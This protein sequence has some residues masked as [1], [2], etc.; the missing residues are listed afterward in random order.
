LILLLAGAWLNVPASAQDLEP[1]AYVNLPT[2]LNF[3]VVGYTRSTG[4]VTADP[5]VPIEDADLTVD[6]MVLGYVRSLALRGRSAKID[7]IVPYSWLDGS[8]RL[9]G[10]PLQ[11]SVD[12]F[13]DPSV[14]L[15]VNLWG[16]P[17]LSPQEFAAYRQ[18]VVVGA[19]VRVSA[20]L[21]QY[22]HGRYVNLGTNRW[23]IKPE[24]G[25]SKRWG[26]WSLDLSGAVVL[27]TDNDEYVNDRTLEQ[28]PLYSLQTHVIRMFGRG[29]WAAV[30][31]TWYAGGRTRVEG[32]EKDD[33]KNN[34]RVGLTLAL[35]INAR[36]SLKL[37]AATGVQQRTGTDFDTAGLV[38][39]Y[40]WGAGY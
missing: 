24:L 26:H 6:T 29:I 13:S 32:V 5:A 22:D 40:R 23:S 30:D 31:A 17:A 35:P 4:G 27:F 2:G 33:R 11:R 8:A 10:V 28:D 12:G 14:R 18:D 7:I 25:I 36:H 39:Q 34:S 3:F 38:W 19:S 37:Y 9:D 20:P 21:G 1:R 15:A 16:A